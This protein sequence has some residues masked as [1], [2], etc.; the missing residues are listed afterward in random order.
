MPPLDNVTAFVVGMGR[1]LPADR[2]PRLEGYMTIGVG[3]VWPTGFV[4]AVSFWTDADT[5]TEN[6]AHFDRTLCVCDRSAAARPEHIG[7]PA[8][9]G[10]LPRRPSPNYLH[11]LDNPVA[12]AAL[13]AVGLGCYPVML[14][15]AGCEDG[16]DVRRLL[17]M[18]YRPPG[19]HHPTLWAW[20]A[21]GG[22]FDDNMNHRHVQPA[23]VGEMVARIRECFDHG[24]I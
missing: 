1:D 9:P 24:P 17:A 21:D 23:R 7:L 16:G 19:V 8:R 5:Y 22:E 3:R 15:G 2:L 13:W 18:R 6:P 10:P 12:V 20:S 14:L 11:R 4:P